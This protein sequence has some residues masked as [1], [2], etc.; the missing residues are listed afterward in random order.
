MSVSSSMEIDL[1][2]PLSSTNKSSLCSFFVSSLFAL[3]YKT[4]Y[5][6]V[7]VAIN[8]LP[9]FKFSHQP[10]STLQVLPFSTRS[11]PLHTSGPL[12]I[13]M[14][15]GDGFFRVFSRI[16]VF[17]CHI[18]ATVQ[19]TTHF[20]SVPPHSDIPHHVPFPIGLIREFW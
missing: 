15:Q 14:N 2:H 18:S 12:S 8:P 17:G 3:T 20:S 7:G 4:N 16:P 6:H 10:P 11:S 13:Q 19:D 9:L 1:S 5:Y